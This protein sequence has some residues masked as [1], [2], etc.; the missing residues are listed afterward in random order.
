MLQLSSIQAL[1]NLVD[2]PDE[3]I[4]EHVRGELVKCGTTALP[5]LE[6]T[7]E[8]DLFGSKHHERIDKIIQ[9]IQFEEV[10]KELTNWLNSSEKDLIKGA[11]IVAK[12]EN[13]ALDES[14]ILNKIQNIRRDIWL[15]LNE[16]QTSFEKVKIFNKIFFSHHKFEG[17]K[18]DYFSPANSLINKVL[19]TRKG[20]PLSLSLL[21]SVIAQSLD[22]PIY[23]VNLP[24]HFILAYMDVNG[25]HAQN[26]QEN[27]F[28]VLFYI[29]TFSRGSIFDTEEIKS[30]LDGLKVEHKRD[31]FEPCSNTAI[32]RRMLTNLISSYQ[33]TG[34]SQIIDDLIELRSILN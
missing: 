8:T 18:E 13:H 28:G 9:E 27:E 33:Q 19:E 25:V 22:L 29:N 23:G 21:Y 30:F 1:I 31:F 2:D 26:D 34:K 32:I 3:Q 12:Y 17:D 7:W 5:I 11:C 10:K 24:N 15:E 4:Y 16:N 14:E 20:N 6:S